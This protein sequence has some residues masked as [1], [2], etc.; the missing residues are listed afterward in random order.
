MPP[1]ATVSRR[2]LKGPA[3]HA[4]PGAGRAV[5]ATGEFCCGLLQL[6]ESEEVIRG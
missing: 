4:M 3:P 6:H 1:T 2:H 5:A